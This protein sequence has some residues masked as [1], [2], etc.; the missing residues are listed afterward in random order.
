MNAEALDDWVREE[1]GLVSRRIFTD[2]EIR[3]LE[4]ERIFNRTWLLLGHESELANPGDFVTRRMGDDL[5]L[6]VRGADGRIRA[7]LNSCRH[8]G[9]QVCRADSGNA[10]RFICPYHHWTYDTAGALRT[11]S[12]DAFY[13][14]KSLAGLGLTPVAKLDTY[15]G[16]IFASWNPDAVSLADH[17][18]DL[19]W[20][21]DLLFHRTPGGMTVLAPPQRWVID[22]NWKL[23]GINFIDSQHAIRVHLGPVA[24]SQVPGGPSMAD[25]NR[26]WAESP[27]VSIA[28]GHG[29]VL[30]P[31]PPMIPDFVG[32]PPE[33]VPLYRQTLD[34]NQLALVRRFFGCVGTI[35]PNASWVHP[36]LAIAP[37]KPPVM[38]LNLRVWHPLEAGKIE[39]WSWY[40]AEKE[41][42]AEWRE[43]LLTCAIQTFGV[44]G[45]FEEDDAE[46]WAGIARATRGSKA[47]EQPMDF[48][49]GASIPPALDFAGPGRAYPSLFSEHAQLN[50]FRVWK[51]WMRTP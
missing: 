32:C 40:L 43:K 14:K 1:D 25:L 51:Q 38:F 49:A 33:L 42:S 21:L 2:P 36:L 18:G 13:E 9:M 8:R 4:I 44:G 37:E 15:R 31:N 45:V 48:R 30:I 28:E 19:R 27:Q 46:V 10:E 50:F 12:F 39:V 41:S 3:D 17:L 26:L 16:L 23:T 34:E 22:T 7:F 29:C 47:R 6:V 24:V 35:F 5:V 11:T 20:Y